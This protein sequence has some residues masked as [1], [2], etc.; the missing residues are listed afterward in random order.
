ML[1]TNQFVFLLDDLSV[2]LYGSSRQTSFFVERKTSDQSTRVLQL[3]L[4][5][6][7]KIK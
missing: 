3:Q 2:R 7:R 1:V 4:V 5:Q 6:A